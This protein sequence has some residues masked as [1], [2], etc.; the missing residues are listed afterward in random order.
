MS[1]GVLWIILLVARHFN[2]LETPLRKVDIGGS[3]ITSH[4]DVF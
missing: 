3:K 4:H 2:L 1:E